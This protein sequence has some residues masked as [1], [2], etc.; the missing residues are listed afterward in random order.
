MIPFNVPKKSR[1]FPGERLVAIDTPS[2]TRVTFLLRCMDLEM[3]P[4][5]DVLVLPLSFRIGTNLTS[6]SEFY[7]HRSRL[8]NTLSFKWFGEIIKNTLSFKWL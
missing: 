1:V 3:G 2:F 4:D 5:S 7:F 8:A 6:S